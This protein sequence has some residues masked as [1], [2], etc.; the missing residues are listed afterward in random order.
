ML[1]IGTRSGIPSHNVGLLNR[2][3]REFL[4]GGNNP[5]AHFRN[6]CIDNQDPRVA[7]LNGNVGSGAG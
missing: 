2:F 5:I 7:D 3:I 1:P 6:T 4:Y